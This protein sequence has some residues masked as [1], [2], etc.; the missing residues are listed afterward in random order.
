MAGPGAPQCAPYH[1]PDSLQAT[2]N[3]SSASGHAPFNRSAPDPLCIGSRPL[4]RLGP[5][6][7]HTEGSAQDAKEKHP[8]V[9]DEH[10]Y[11]S[12]DQATFFVGADGEG[13]L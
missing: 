8:V 11:I 9:C 2:T 12:H 4:V 3:Y 13:E 10:L 5:R 7:E 6:A 1:S